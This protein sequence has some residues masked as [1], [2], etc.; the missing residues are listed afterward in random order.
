MV[1]ALLASKYFS[2][3][4]WEEM[5]G[6]KKKKKKHAFWTMPVLF[7]AKKKKICNIHDQIDM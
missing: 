5:T 7:N 3:S 4:V 6:E 2:H 1:K